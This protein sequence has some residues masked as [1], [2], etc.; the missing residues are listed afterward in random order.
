MIVYFHDSTPSECEIDALTLYVIHQAVMQGI[1]ECR[2][3]AQF[4]RRS[5]MLDVKYIDAKKTFSELLGD[6][7]RPK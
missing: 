4:G 3:R 7:E 5:L 6:T 1:L 2:I